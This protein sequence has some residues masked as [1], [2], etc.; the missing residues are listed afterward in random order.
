LFNYDCDIQIM[1]NNLFS[2]CS[3]T[4]NRQGHRPFFALSSFLSSPERS[5][6]LPEYAEAL[7]STFASQGNLTSRQKSRTVD[8]RVLQ[9][10]DAAAIESETDTMSTDSGGHSDSM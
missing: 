3:M 5:F 9:F 6:A 4:S 2:S 1:S 7:A 8:P 10:V